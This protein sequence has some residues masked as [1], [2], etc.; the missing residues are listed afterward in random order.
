MGKFYSH[1]RLVS[2]DTVSITGTRT[3]GSGEETVWNGTASAP[4]AIASPGQLTLVSTSAQDD[5]AINVGATPEVQEIT[6]S[7][8]PSTGTPPVAD[9]YESTVVLGDPGD[10]Y[11]LTVK[12]VTHSHVASGDSPQVDSVTLSGTPTSGTPDTPATFDVWDAS[13]GVGVPT[14]GDQFSV[15]IDGND[16]GPVTYM[17][18]VFD[19][20][21]STVVLGSIGDSYSLTVGTDTHDHVVQDA[22]AKQ[23]STTIHAGPYQGAGGGGPMTFEVTGSEGGW[24]YPTMGTPTATDVAVALKNGVNGGIA[25]MFGVV[26]GGTAGNGDVYTITIAG[27]TAP[28]IYTATVPADTNQTVAEALRDAI[29]SGSATYTAIAFNAKDAD[30]AVILTAVA[31]GSAAA[32]VITAGVVG[33]GGCFSFA[34]AAGMDASALWVASNVGPVLTLTFHTTGT[35]SESVTITD[36]G[37]PLS[38]P[39]SPY[40]DSPT[41]VAGAA[42]EDATAAATAIVAAF[43]TPFGYTIGNVAGDITVTGTGPLPLSVSSSTDSTSGGTFASVNTTPG[44]MGS[45]P[46]SDLFTAIGGVDPLYNASLGIANDVILTAKTAGAVAPGIVVAST[47]SITVTFTANNTIPGA[48][49]IPGSPA[50]YAEIRDG[51]HTYHVGYPGGGLSALASSLAYSVNGQDGYTA[52]V[53]GIDPTKVLIQGTPGFTFTD[54]SGSGVSGSVS[55]VSAGGSGESASDVADALVGQFT[56]DGYTIGNL[57]GVITCTNTVPGLAVPLGVSSYKNG[58]SGSFSSV[59]TATGADAGGASVASVTDGLQSCGSGAYTSGGLGALATALAASINGHNGYTASALSAVVTVSGPY[60]YAFTDTSTGGV[61]TSANTTEP[62]SPGSIGDPGTGIATVLLSYLDADGIR[63]SESIALN[64]TT[65]VLTVAE[66]IKAILGMT[67]LSVGSN[68]SAVGNV[69][70]TDGSSKVYA[71][72]VTGRNE[73]SQAVYMVPA[74]NQLWL[75]ALSG[76]ATAEARIR[77][78]AGNPA[79]TQA[80]AICGQPGIHIDPACPLGPF[81][82]GTVIKVLATGVSPGTIVAVTCDGYLDPAING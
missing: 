64:G 17:A 3:L 24:Q 82:S 59:H 13:I 20:W 9:E 41:I 72:I 43:V 60:G 69:K 6:L 11:S 40:E 80:E 61:T 32:H 62:G 16:Y 50:S 81:P 74:G 31:V 39:P 15:T 79:L 28:Y 8:S 36:N 75:T 5:A 25:D 30:W 46:I 38:T 53:D 26:I 67:A 19:V 48:D 47:T 23:V 57:A 77:L 21:D 78:V 76:S 10:S 63:K 29:N 42:A 54:Y 1:G 58:I 35:T 27:D 2:A 55:L 73:N 66:D 56:P 18:P 34:L 68:G 37:D 65:N 52:Y 45:N 71:E 12:G 33:T 49:L 14:D 51:T 4:D 22:T 44:S 70:A 7:G